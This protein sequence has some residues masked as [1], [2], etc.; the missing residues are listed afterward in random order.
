MVTDAEQTRRDALRVL[1]GAGLGAGLMAVADH[2]WSAR[3]SDDSPAPCAT[4]SSASPSPSVSRGREVAPVSDVPARGALDVSAAVGEPAYLVR[5]G[6]SVRLLSA[7]CTHAECL[8]A[9]APDDRQ[10]QCPCHLGVYDQ[11]GTVVSGPPPRPLDELPTV[12]E[13]GTVYLTE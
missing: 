8:A 5:S 12:V 3:A 2:G 6:A 7:I 10:F 9:W 13:A 11:Q 4:E 1:A